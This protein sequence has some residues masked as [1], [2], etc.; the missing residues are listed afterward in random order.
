[1][2]FEIFLMLL[3]V[4]STLTGLFTEGIKKF[5]QE[6]GKAYRANALAGYVAI[7]LS[8]LVS[9]GY[10]IL[11]NSAFGTQML[12]YVV[13]LVLLSWLAAMIGYDKIVQTI[14][15]FKKTE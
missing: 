7:A 2:T 15:Q 9:I 11:T 6:K 3:F 8:V 12:V 10:I 5:L 1:M 13:A 14:S 4:V